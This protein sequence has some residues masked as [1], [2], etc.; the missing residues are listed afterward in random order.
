M[1]AGGFNQGIGDNGGLNGMGNGITEA[2][3]A[4]PYLG[5]E[6]ED[7]QNYGFEL[8]MFN[9]RINLVVDYFNN[10]RH[11]ILL[12]RKTVPQIGGFRQDPW[13]NFGR[14]RNQGIDLSLDM[15]H[16][17]G[18]VNLSARGTFTFT[19]NKILEYDELPQNTAI[20]Q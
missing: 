19:R 12:Q 15:N 10:E 5:W 6:I 8:G 3:F 14:V 4:A 17:L 11:N 18:D 20:R 13:E 1:G 9:N 16:K 2:R 7:K